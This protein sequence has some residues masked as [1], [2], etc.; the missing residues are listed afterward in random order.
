MDAAHNQL[1]YEEYKMECDDAQ[2]TGDVVAV[3][4]AES[5]RC[6]ELHETSLLKYFQHTVD[7]EAKYLFLCAWIYQ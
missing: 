7:T 3:L 1:C 6:T 4:R 5:D 2:R